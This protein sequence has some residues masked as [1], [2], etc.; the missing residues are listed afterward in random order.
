MR[1]NENKYIWLVVAVVSVLLTVHLFSHDEKEKVEVRQPSPVRIDVVKCSGKMIPNQDIEG[2]VR[3]ST[4]CLTSSDTVIEYRQ[5]S[6]RTLTLVPAYTSSCMYKAD[7]AIIKI[8]T[9]V[10]GCRAIDSA[11]DKASDNPSEIVTF[12]EPY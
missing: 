4:Y 1:L 3:N 9:Y 6:T 12:V 8:R 5:S 10:A 7:H 11:T 2:R